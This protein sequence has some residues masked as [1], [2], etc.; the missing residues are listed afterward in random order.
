MCVCEP[1][2]TEDFSV[3]KEWMLLCHPGLQ[4]E[5]CDFEQDDTCKFPSLVL[6][7]VLAHCILVMETQSMYLSISGGQQVGQEWRGRLNDWMVEIRE[8]S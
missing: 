7:S 5:Y 6:T 1:D 8:S 2:P 3:W 4:E